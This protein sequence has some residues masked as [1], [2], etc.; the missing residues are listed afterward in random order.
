MGHD[1]PLPPAYSRKRFALSWMAIRAPVGVFAVHRPGHLIT[2]HWRSPMSVSDTIIPDTITGNAARTAMLRKAIEKV[3]TELAAVQA[4]LPGNFDTD[5][6]ELDVMLAAMNGSAVEDQPVE[7][8][9]VEDQTPPGAAIEQSSDDDREQM[10]PAAPSLTLIEAQAA[11]ANWQHK[12]QLARSALRE[13][14][15]EQRATRAKLVE[16]I[17][18]FLR[19]GP[20]SRDDLMREYL[21]SEQRKRINGESRRGRV[22]HGPSVVDIGRAGQSSVNRNYAP[23]R[24]PDMMTGRRTYSIADSVARS[25]SG[26]IDTPGIVAVPR[27]VSE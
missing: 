25:G 14:D 17:N 2:N 20:I 6:A 26:I 5:Q 1:E 8:Q 9:T 18:F 11:L 13:R 21:A 23:K 7:D 16:S 24:R 15:L 27:V 10:H 22:A 12:A 4:A 3:G 19:G